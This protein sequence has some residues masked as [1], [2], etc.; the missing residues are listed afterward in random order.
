MAKLNLPYRIHAGDSVSFTDSVSNYPAS[1]GW[2]LRYTLVT[3]KNKYLLDSVA[4]GDNHDI[5]ATTSITAIWAPGYY[6]WVAFAVKGAERYT[7]ATGNIE[8]LPDIT[9]G[10]IDQRAHVEKVLDAIEATIENKASIDQQSMSINGRSISR[11]AF[12]DLII[13][14]DKY[15]GEL[16]SLKRA[17][18]LQNGLAAGNKILVRF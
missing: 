3:A 6:R 17:E 4:N 8:I 13:L 7:I 5:S 12:T 1:A 15:K 16:V 9:S 18:R 2:L 14:R 11:Y 10:A